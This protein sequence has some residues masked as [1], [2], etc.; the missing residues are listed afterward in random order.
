M[1]AKDRLKEYPCR[2]TSSPGPCYSIELEPAFPLDLERQIFELVAELYPS[3]IPIL[4]RVCRQVHAWLEPLLYRVLNL[5]DSNLTKAIKFSLKPPST[6]PQT[7]QSLLSRIR[8]WY[9]PPEPV[10]PPRA[11][12]FRSAVRHVMCTTP[13]NADKSWQTISRFLRLHPAL[14][15]LVVQKYSATVKTLPSSNRKQLPKEMRPTRLTLEM[16]NHCSSIDFADPLF[17]AVTH[18]TLLAPSRL[19]P[20]WLRS[21]LTAL[22]HLCVTENIASNIL[23]RIFTAYPTLRAFVAYW[24]RTPIPRWQREKAAT[25][26]QLEWKLANQNS[27][28]AVAQWLHMRTFELELRARPGADAR[29]VLT[30]AP[31]FFDAWERGARSGQDMWLCVEQ[32]IA[33]KRCGEIEQTTYVLDKGDRWVHSFIDPEIK[34]TAG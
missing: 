31:D 27:L 8:R 4:L 33:R 15:E 24:W 28:D 11:Q 6:E 23:P 3:T 30:G 16:A 34:W 12:F 26:S 9:N 29:I 7:H 1:D 10:E 18:L 32:F 2:A 5:D 14:F 22:T 17:S 13:D 19:S 25:S 20:N 21:S